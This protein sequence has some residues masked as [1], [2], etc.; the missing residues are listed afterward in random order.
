MPEPRFLQAVF[1]S[2]AG[3]PADLPPDRGLEIA[4]SGR[5]NAGKSSA[6]NAL[7]GRKR[8]AFSSKT[9]GRTQT[10]NYFRLE[11]GG[12]LVDLPGYGYARVAGET[13]VR[14]N[15]LLTDYVGRRAALVGLVVMMDIR[16]PLTE[17]DRQL[18]GWFR[19]SGKR[20]HILLTKADKLSRGAALAAVTATRRALEGLSG[21]PTVQLFSARTGLGVED[22]LAVIRGWHEES[23]RNIHP[24]DLGMPIFKTTGPAPDRQGSAEPRGSRHGEERGTKLG[25]PASLLPAKGEKPNK[26]PRSKG[27]HRGQK[28]LDFHQ[29]SCSGR[30]SGR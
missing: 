17:L 6:I 10:I 11:N 20:A 9:P 24:S 26:N 30:R 22:A 3:V 23:L 16:H 28:S 27:M 1:A 14:W 5:S 19:P 15:R 4:F 29:G 8:L 7:T 12:Y 21:A 2:S 25:T 13:R 18:L